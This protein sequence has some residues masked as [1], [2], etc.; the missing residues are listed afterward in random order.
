VGLP[1][2]LKARKHVDKL[3]AKM[4]KREKYNLGIIYKK[5]EEICENPDKFKP[6][7][8]PMQNLRRV[9]VLKSFVITY[10]IDESTHT[11]WIEDYAHHDEVY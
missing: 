10:S 2:N 11:V 4:A 3:F 5:I 1:Y 8:A 7:H 6:L 9:Q